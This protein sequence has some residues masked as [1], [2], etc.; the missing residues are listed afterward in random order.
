MKERAVLNEP[1]GS[2]LEEVRGTWGLHDRLSASSEKELQ[3]ELEKGPGAKFDLHLWVARDGGLTASNAIDSFYHLLKLAPELGYETQLHGLDEMPADI[4]KRALVEIQ[5]SGEWLCEHCE[6]IPSEKCYYSINENL[7]LAAK[8]IKLSEEYGL[9]YEPAE[10]YKPTIEGVISMIEEK[11][12]SL[13]KH[14]YEIY[15]NNSLKEILNFADKANSISEKYSLGYEKSQFYGP[16]IEA[17]LSKI[18]SEGALLAKKPYAS[19]L[20]SV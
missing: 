15:F 1:R 20:K 4:A 7:K 18:E 13:G 2:F 11:G 9:G 5:K 19:Y 10:F 8:T 14:T 16:V 3:S 12:E 6:H 17:A